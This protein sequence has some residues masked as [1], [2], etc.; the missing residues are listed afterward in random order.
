MAVSNTYTLED[1]YGSRVVVRGAGYILNNE[2]GD[3]NAR[4]GVTT[5]D[6]PHRHEPNLIAPG[7]RMLSSHDADDRREGRQA[8]ARH[9]QPRRADD[10]QHRAVRRRRT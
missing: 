10:H 4:P 8:G 3:F 2:M 7:K 1:S 5:R 6:G 9:R